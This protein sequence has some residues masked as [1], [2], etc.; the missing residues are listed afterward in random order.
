MLC[1][2]LGEYGGSEMTY[3]DH[4]L[5][6]EE[7]SRA[8][9]SIALSYGAHSNLCINQ[10]VRNATEEQKQKYLPDVSDCVYCLTIF[11]FHSM[12]SDCVY[13]LT[14]FSFHSMQTFSKL[15]GAV[16]LLLKYAASVRSY[17]L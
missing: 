6:M 4:C 16:A 7:M 8:S 1:T 9:A 11:I 17:L 3:L 14:I 2:F 5:I 12:Q 15:R 10:L 13:C